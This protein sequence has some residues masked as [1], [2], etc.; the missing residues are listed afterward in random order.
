MIQK[1]KISGLT[2]EACQKLITKRLTK[3]TGVENVTVALSGQADIVAQREITN[4]EIMQALE[5]TKYQLEHY[6]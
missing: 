3:V 1:I 2:C 6:E 5:G 4:Q